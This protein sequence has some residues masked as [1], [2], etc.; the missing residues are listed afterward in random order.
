MVVPMIA[1][2]VVGQTRRLWARLASR[3]WG[4]PR[5]AVEKH[6]EAAAAAAEVSAIGVAREH[7]EAAAAAAEVSAI[8]ELQGRLDALRLDYTRALRRIEMSSRTPS[9]GG[10]E[11]GTVHSAS[12]ASPA[13]PDALYAD[14]EDRFRGEPDVILDRQSIYLPDVRAASERCP[15][16]PALDIGCGRGE[17]LGL[18]S[19][20]NIDAV[21]I[22]GNSTF[23]SH[24]RDLGL[25]ASQGDGLS[26]LRESSDGEY[27]VISLLHVVEHLAYDYLAAL[28][29]ESVRSLDPN[30]LLIVETPNCA[31][32]SVA[33]STFW[34][35]PTHA[36]PLHPEVLRFLIDRAGFRSME[37]RYLHEVA[38]DG[39]RDADLEGETP[40]VQLLAR[41]VFGW[42]DLGVVARL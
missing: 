33:A 25:S 42:G 37:F 2:V 40:V 3:L 9:S 1:R 36:R 31:S 34:I 8:R 7:A 14:I 5:P 24:C 4:A 18:L 30:G 10:R 32:L 20:N 38:P 27:S 41:T 11:R 23:V 35:D 26:H 22:D 6:A 13:V 16:K 39:A 19:E 28:L 21:G 17:W 15:G 29:A 12:I